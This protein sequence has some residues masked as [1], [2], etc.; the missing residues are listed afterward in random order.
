MLAQPQLGQELSSRNPNAETLTLSPRPAP[1]FE[2]HAESPCQRGS[3]TSGPGGKREAG[4]GNWA[5]PREEEPGTRAQD[6]AGRARG[7]TRAAS[8]FR[9][10]LRGQDSRSHVFNLETSRSLRRVTGYTYM[11]TEVSAALCNADACMPSRTQPA[12][13]H[14]R[15][16]HATSRPP[17]PLGAAR[18]SARRAAAGARA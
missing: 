13:L 17:G 1:L 4:P 2:R 6:T 16:P 14:S 15:H 11:R 8:D 5:A 12:L 9:P 18:P 3:S 10:P 7:G